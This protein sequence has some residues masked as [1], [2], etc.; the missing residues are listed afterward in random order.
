MVSRD[1]LFVLIVVNAV[2]S[3]TKAVEKAR[4]VGGFSVKV[5]VECQNYDEAVEALTA[6]SSS[7]WKIN[8]WPAQVQMWQCLITWNQN[9]F[10]RKRKNWKN[11]FHIK[12]LKPAVVSPSI[13]VFPSFKTRCHSSDSAEIFPSI[14]WCHLNGL[15]HTIRPTLWLFSQ[16]PS[17]RWIFESHTRCEFVNQ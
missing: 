6:G 14:R 17:K 9:G 16:Y 11:S 12:S 5:E 1:P 3:I 2:G 7:C 4:I 15:A 13:V 8:I 10:I